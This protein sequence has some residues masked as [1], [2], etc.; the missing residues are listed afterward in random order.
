MP[1][2]RTALAGGVAGGVA[3]NEVAPA[4]AEA[5]AFAGPCVLPDPWAVC[6]LPNFE[7]EARD[8]TPGRR[9]NRLFASDVSASVPVTL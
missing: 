9:L 1:G 3:P 4:A 8:K 6:E 7:S 2:F 5:A